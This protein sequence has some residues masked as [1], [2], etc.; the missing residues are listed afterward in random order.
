MRQRGKRER[1]I[2]K[3]DSTQSPGGDMSGDPLLNE[4]ANALSLEILNRPGIGFSALLCCQISCK[5]L[6]R[7]VSFPYLQTQTVTFLDALPLQISPTVCCRLPSLISCCD[8][9]KRSCVSQQKWVLQG[10]DWPAEARQSC[11]SGRTDGQTEAAERTA[12]AEARWQCSLMLPGTA[13]L[14]LG[15]MPAAL[16][17]EIRLRESR[18]HLPFLSSGKTNGLASL[19]LRPQKQQPQKGCSGRRVEQQP[20]RLPKQKE[21]IVF[22]NSKRCFFPLIQ[23]SAYQ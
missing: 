8:H 4:I 16:A 11:V 20:K 9:F 1:D 3:W 23:I 12:S 5:S 22:L 19:K 6:D 2:G 13:K 18:F 15:S 14:L 17:V 7:W 21:H 10:R